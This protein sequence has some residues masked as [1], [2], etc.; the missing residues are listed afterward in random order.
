MGWMR[1]RWLDYFQIQEILFFFKAS[2]LS[3]KLTQLSVNGYQGDPPPPKIKQPWCEVGPSP[4]SNGEYTSRRLR[5]VACMGVITTAC[6]WKPQ[7]EERDLLEDLDMDGRIILAWMNLQEMGWKS[8]NW[9]VW[10]TPGLM[11]GSY[12]DRNEL[13]GSRKCGI[14]P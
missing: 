10:L 9:F 7:R 13:F 1:K 11:V 4:P 14:F 2:R 12:K 3:L 6:G 8:V 5:Y